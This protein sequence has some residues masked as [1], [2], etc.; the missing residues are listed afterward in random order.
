M[1][2]LELD[3]GNTRIKW[4]RILENRAE[5]FVDGVSANENEFTSEQANFE[6]PD[7]IRFC[8]VRGEHV[9]QRIL[10][11]SQKH[12]NLNPLVARVRR[13]CGGVKINYPDVSCLGVDRWLAML[14]AFKKSKGACVVV[15][16]GTAFTLDVLNAEGVH[17]GGYILPGLDLMKKDLIANTNISLNANV[18]ESS[19]RLGNSTD[20]AVLNG[21]SAAL[22]ALIQQSISNF[23][24]LDLKLTVFFSGG[25]GE[26]LM[27]L[28]DFANSRSEASL[29]LDGLSIA[30]VDSK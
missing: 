2:I 9:T 24:P 29:V 1:T 28:T 23:L 19:I 26:K 6:K 14:S 21:C 20:E 27:G 17:L 3:V 18:V 10:D 13:E 7:V 25:D 5:V 22:V 16:S 11:W 30:C 4:R 8:N 12:W 15:D